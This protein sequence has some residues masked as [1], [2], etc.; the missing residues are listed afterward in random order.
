VFLETQRKSLARTLS[1][2][3]HHR[4]QGRP[5]RSTALERVQSLG[6]LPSNNSAHSP[7]TNY[8]SQSKKTILPFSA[9]MKCLR[10]WVSVAHAYNPSYS[11]GRDQKDHTQ[12]QPGKTTD[13]T[14]SQKKPIKMGW[15]TSGVAQGEGLEI[16]P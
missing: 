10:S 11:R 12:K 15:E 5:N 6:Q 8:S 1:T 14:L 16:K 2:S 4:A 7:D 9:A 13:E 3:N